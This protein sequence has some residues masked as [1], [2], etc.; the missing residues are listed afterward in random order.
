M[1]IF[2]SVR[3]LPIVSGALTWGEPSD[4]GM[5]KEKGDWRGDHLPNLRRVVLEELVNEKEH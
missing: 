3:L 1:N 5:Q 4:R 2:V